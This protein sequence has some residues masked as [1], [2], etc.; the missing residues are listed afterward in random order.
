MRRNV[1]IAM[2][3]VMA[4]IVGSAAMADQIRRQPND[5]EKSGTSMQVSLTAGGQRY[6][7]SAPGQCTHAPTASIYGAVSEL[8]TAQQ[9][10]NGKSLSLSLWQPKDGSK[11]MVSLT[12][13]SG[14]SQHRVSTIKGAKIVGS[15]KTQFE[16]AGKGGTFTVYA[17][18]AEGADIMGTIKCDA[19]APHIAEGGL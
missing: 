10:D 15:A 1:Q 12:V 2:C 17:K 4:V 8:W 14:K 5:P 3:G 18:S 11:P 19:F 13:S 16:A 6:E 7:S 9:S